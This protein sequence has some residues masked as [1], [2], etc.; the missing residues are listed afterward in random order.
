[1][2]TPTIAQIVA[3]IRQALYGR[4]VRENIALGIEKCYT[5]VTNGVTSADTAATNAN[6]KANLANAAAINAGNATTAANTAAT[7]ANNAATAAN[8]AATNANNKASL[9]NA[10]IEKIDNMTVSATSNGT[11]SPTATV[12][13]VD[14]HIHISFGLQKGDKGDKGKDFRIRRSF[15]SIAAMEAYDPSTDTSDYKVEEFDCVM[16]DTGSVEDDV[17]GR[18]YCYEPNETVVWHYIGDLSGKQGITGPQGQKGDTGATPNFTIGTVTTGEPGTSVIVTITGTA[19]NPVLNFTIPKGATGDI[20]TVYAEDI[21]MSSTNSNTISEEIGFRPRL[22]Y[23]TTTGSGGTRY[24]TISDL[25][26]LKNGDIFLIAFNSLNTSSSY[27]TLN[28]NNTGNKYLSYG[29]SSQVFT[30]GYFQSGAII[31]LRYDANNDKYL[32][33]NQMKASTTT[34]G[35]TILS[36]DITSTSQFTAATS[37]AVKAVN[38]KIPTLMVGATSSDAGT[39]GLVPAPSAGDQGKALFGDGTW[40]QVADPSDMTGATSSTNG[41]HGLVPAPSAGDQ[42]KALFGD[43]TWK[44]VA[45]P[46]DMTGASS[47]SDGTHGLVPAPQAGDQGKALFGDGTWKQVADP[48]DMTGA[49]S[50]A[51]GA[52]GLVP[53]P[54]A[55]EQNYVLTG[56]GTWQV[57]PGA[58]VHISQITV[59]NTSGSYEQVVEDDHI[60]PDMKATQIEISRPYVFGDL[61]NITPGQGQYT[62]SCNDVSGTD[63]I[64]ISFIKVIQ[65]PLNVTSTEFDIL[66]NRLMAVENVCTQTNVTIE[67]TDWTLTNGEYIYQWESSLIIGTS[68]VQV[69][70]RDGA[71]AAGIENFDYEYETGSVTFVSSTLPTADLPLTVKIMHTKTGGIQSLTGDDISTEAVSGADTVEDALEIINGNLTEYLGGTKILYF[72]NVSFT[73]TNNSDASYNISSLDERVADAKAIIPLCTSSGVPS[74][75]YLNG[76]HTVVGVH[77]FNSLNQ[78]LP[79]D[80][81]VFI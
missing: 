33:I 20:S 71:E 47:S 25:D 22:F 75:G 40:K 81:I 73:F 24:C 65:D 42:N 61:I 69:E 38:D 60:T 45:D 77:I 78:T 79:F 28:I 34:Y 53:A 32:V 36:T 50:S 6:Q 37:S 23:G 9:V 56:S 1:M 7:A 10:A 51:N 18:L 2:A 44:Q 12:S 19:E 58:N 80:L 74:V 26:E 16:I 72:H 67:P 70:L 27:I 59:T 14:G 15:V 76:A 63:T 31:P 21:E 17:T 68:D 35:L 46:N 57:S 30:N 29:N 3:Q 66:N 55:G 8:N 64:K 62:I 5:D 41:T 48:N 13:E 11:N 39:Q 49:T 43:G 54:S 52:H 4:D